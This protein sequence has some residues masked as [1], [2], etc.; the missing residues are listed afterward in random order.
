VVLWGGAFPSG[1]LKYLTF[2][3]YLESVPEETC[4]LVE[5]SGS[6]TALALDALGRERRLPVV[7]VT[8]AAGTAHLR[9]RGFG[10]EVHTVHGMSEAWELA[11][12]YERRG[13]CWP[14]QLANAAL[15]RCVEGWAT[16]LREVV[17]DAYPGVR[18]LV[19][20]FGTGATVVGLH[21]AFGMLGYE[22]VALQPAP[23]RSLPGW[24]RWAEQNLGERDV[25]H[26]YQQEVVLQA[27][28]ARDT[29]GLAALLGWTRAERKPEE[30]LIVSHDAC[31]PWG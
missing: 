10:G 4:G 26:P 22:V 28:G 9:A 18:T 19:C 31:P 11:L 2:S 8:D 6:S 21:R 5:L 24:R 30:V 7:A 3:R 14:R 16:R 15:I 12:G 23:G 13:F 17:R 29:D 27:A 1:S 25:F 20:G